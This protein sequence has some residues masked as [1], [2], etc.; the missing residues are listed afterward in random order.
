MVTEAV[1]KEIYKTYKKPPTSREELRLPHYLEL[2][3]KHHNLK[4]DDD[5]III[6]DLEEFNPF[7][8]FL[9][10]S[11]NAILEFDKVIAL[12]FS[13]HILFLGKNDKSL[14]VNF[15]PEDEKSLFNKIFGRR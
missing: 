2:L 6:E 12:V 15:K 5:E 10:R 13:N 4:Q 11:I 1:I 14:R 7:R 3:N 8:R 9:I